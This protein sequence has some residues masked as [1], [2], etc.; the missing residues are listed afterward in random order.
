MKSGVRKKVNILKINKRGVLIINK[1]GEVYLAP[2]STKV[3]ILS[4][5]PNFVQQ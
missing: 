2:E 3:F 1:R 5:V 4:Y